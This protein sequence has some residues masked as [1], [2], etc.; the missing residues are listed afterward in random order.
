M[1]GWRGA[2]GV[3]QRR[4]PVVDEMNHEDDEAC[5]AAQAVQVSRRGNSSVGQ[6]LSR[7]GAI[8]RYEGGDK[9]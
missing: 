9:R 3:S 5:N 4:E 1:V 8:P 7:G 6:R 2:V